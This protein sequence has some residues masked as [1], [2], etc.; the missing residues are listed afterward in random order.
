MPANLKIVPI[1][2]KH[3]SGDA[4]SPVQLLEEFLADVKAG[5]IAPIKLSLQYV[6]VTPAGS[7]LPRSWQAG[8]SRSEEIALL[9][10]A[11]TN[12]IQDWKD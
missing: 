12:A 3:P 2:S 9:E 7:W 11:K 10:I 8:C 5:K 1:A 6:E 4:W